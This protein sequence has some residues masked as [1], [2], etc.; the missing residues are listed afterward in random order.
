MS[1][2]PQKPMDE[3]TPT[4]RLGLVKL[5][6][7]EFEGVVSDGRTHTD[8]QGR[9]SA[10][11]L[12]G[13]ELGLAAWLA[14]GGQ[15]VVIV[16]Q[17]YEPARHWAKANGI[18]LREHNGQKNACLQ[19]IIFEHMGQPRQLCYLGCDLDDLPAMSIAGTA[20]AVAGADPWCQGAAHLVLSR[21]GGGGAVRELID[22]MLINRQP[23][24]TPG[25]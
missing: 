10:A 18:A 1:I 8:D 15:A 13:D 4:E 25:V 19:A 23:N 17:G 16:R 3:L 9:R 5:L 24:V 12:R 6:V 21:P 20:V 11:T 7:M 22:M 2:I 14:E